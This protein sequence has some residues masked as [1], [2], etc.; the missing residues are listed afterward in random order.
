MKRVVLFLLL[1]T[2]AMGA[3][4]A[5]RT[6]VVA[7][8]PF[9]ATGGRATPD[10]ASRVSRQV[11]AEL[12]SWGSLNVLQTEAG[13]EY[14]VRGTLSKVGANYIL[15]ATT[16]D[17]RSKKKLNESTE[18]SVSIGEL[19]IFSFCSSIVQNVPLPNYLLGTWQSTINMPD[20]PV[21][22]IIE[23][24]SDRTAI[25]ERY[26]TW[27]HKKNN[28]LRYEGYG[29]GT[30][31]YAGYFV[32]RTITVNSQQIQIDAMTGFNLTLEETLPEQTSVNQGRLGIQF[33]A[34][35]SAFDIINGSLPCGRNY[36]GT[37]VYPSEYI[38]FTRFVKIK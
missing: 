28:S 2:L 7:V 18:Q 3:V 14:I 5:Q 30:Y 29:N 15:T 10:E 4:F 19:S 26:D 16:T 31:S 35:R 20:G 22:C 17:A 32:R 38:G 13:A 9:E 1:M 23:C 34:D 37:A 21:V 27:E 11:V 36:D 24:K 12:N 6:P 33:N 8:I 25:V